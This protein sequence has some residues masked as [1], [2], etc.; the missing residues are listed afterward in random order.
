[1]KIDKKKLGIVIL[2]YNNFTD[3]INLVESLCLQTNFESTCIVVVDNKSTDNSF[4][5]LK[6]LE[7]LNSN[8]H[9]IQSKSNLGY[10]KGN[11][12]GLNFLDKFNIDY[13]AIVNNDVIIEDKLL[14]EKLISEFKEIK[15]LGFIAPVEID[16]SGIINQYCARKKPS[17]FQEI[18]NTFLLY[19]Y[20]FGKKSS[21]K[22]NGKQSKVEVDILSGAFIFT[23]FKFFKNI[24]FFD[25][26]TFLFLEERIISEKVSKLGLKQYVL[27]K[28]NYRHKT[29]ESISK[30]FS[31]IEQQKIYNKSLIYYTK[32]YSNNGAIKSIVLRV[33][34]NFKIFQFKIYNYIKKR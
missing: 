30:K 2:N 17:F 11:N 20:L 5:K 31:N 26:G 29:S 1:M 34:L 15:N 8:I 10:A 33:F 21:Y 32:N 9:V 7:N 6:E 16:S 13:V 19:V 27:P 24:G 28:L 12:V 25:P 4:S 22:I 18:L 3:T 14:F 23:R